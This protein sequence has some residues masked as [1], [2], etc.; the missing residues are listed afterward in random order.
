[1]LDTLKKI[2]CS[3]VNCTWSRYFLNIRKIEDA[4]FDFHLTDG[5]FGT[6]V[7]NPSD[8]SRGLNDQLEDSEF[9][10]YSEHS[11][12]S[13]KRGSYIFIITS[14]DY[15]QK[16]KDA[17][18]IAGFNVWTGLFVLLRSMEGRQLRR[19]G[20]FPQV[21]NEF[22]VVARKP[23]QIQDNFKPRFDEP[24]SLLPCKFPRR[25][26]VI[27]KIPVARPKLTDPD[28]NRIVRV[29]E[30]DV[31]LLMEL[32]VTFCPTGGN[33][34]DG[35]G[36]T[37]TTAI[38]CLKTGRPCVVVE[39]DKHCFD[40]A[41][42]R[43]YT[44][45]VNVY[46]SPSETPAAKQQ[47][48]PS[49]SRPLTTTINQTSKDKT[50]DDQG[51]QESREL[52]GDE[53][54]RCDSDGADDADAPDRHADDTDTTHIRSDV[55]SWSTNLTRATYQCVSTVPSTPSISQDQQTASANIHSK[56]QGSDRAGTSTSGQHSPGLL[57][58][59]NEL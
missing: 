13:L 52:S 29:A 9:Q 59:V 36:G 51:S 31:G 39:S 34:F 5:P 46:S 22:G 27:D 10:R 4:D 25:L 23:G 42:Q 53:Y 20:V 18:R 37:L 43:L 50:L 15:A 28:N 45:Y 1:M 24:Y 41:V 17:L 38:A 33:T 21:F 54:E 48:P 7:S 3:V 12:K 16:W 55:Q 47:L 35:F 58:H 8:T 32:M 6:P 19:K 11:F 44:V 14:A 56:A 40:L 49:S 26:G 30:K 2:G 57:S